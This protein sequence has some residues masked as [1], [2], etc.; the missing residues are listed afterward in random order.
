[1]KKAYLLHTA[2]AF[3]CPVEVNTFTIADMQ[4]D[5]ENPNTAE[6]IDFVHDEGKVLTLQEL[7]NSIN[8]ESINL[9]DHYILIK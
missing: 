6:F 9:K 4:T 8:F 1:M 5:E 2:K 7:A 3:E